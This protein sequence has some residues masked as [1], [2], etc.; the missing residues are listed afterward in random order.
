MLQQNATGPGWS[1]STCRT[2]R[3]PAFG[4]YKQS[5]FGREFS[6]DTLDLYLEETQAVVQSTGA[7][8]SNPFGL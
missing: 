4:G 8:P 6:I 3:S 2:R 7:R 1:A 5:G